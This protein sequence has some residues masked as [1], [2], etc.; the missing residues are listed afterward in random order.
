M[1]KLKIWIDGCEANVPQRLGSSQV[2]FELLKNLEKIDKQNSY[3]I[4]L[5]NPPMEDLPKE[6][7]GWKYQILKIKKF[8][9]YLAIPFSLFTAK[10]KPDVFFSPTQY[11]PVLSPVKRVMMIFDLSYLLFPQYFKSRDLWQLKL[12]TWISAKV[13][14]HIITISKSAKD[15]ILKLYKKAKEDVTIAYPGFDNQIYHPIRD[16]KKIIEVINKYN[17]TEKY[18]LYTGTIQPRK[19]LISLIEAFKKIDNLTLVIAGKTKGLGRQGWMYEGI[20][21]KPQELG[22]EKK[23]IFTGFVPKEDLPYLMSGAEAFILPSLYEGFGIPPLE[24]MATGTPVIVSN[25]SSLPEVVGDAGILVDPY[26]V[27]QIE[28]AIRTIAFDK[29]LQLKKSKEVLIQAKKFSWEKMA[30]VVLK[31]LERVAND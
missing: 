23:V 17:I 8:K 19:N 3:T 13:T 9:T 24:A 7:I 21:K 26:S 22:I 11:A 14:D 30:K 10:E 15:D 27:G 31:V 25:V 20:L 6:R 28:Q 18:V 16:D 4:L 12:W 2:A 29:K 5:A 1:T